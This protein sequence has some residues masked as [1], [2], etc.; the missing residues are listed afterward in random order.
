MNIR[1]EY[2]DINL[3]LNKEI[4]A[5]VEYL[6]KETNRSTENIFELAMTDF[7]QK[8]NHMFLQD[9]IYDYMLMD[10]ESGNE[11]KFEYD[12]FVVDLKYDD[13]FDYVINTHFME[14]GKQKQLSKVI[15]GDDELRHYL[16]QLTLMNLPIN[17]K[18]MQ[19]YVNR[20]TDYR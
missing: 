2:K 3:R 8:H 9:Y 7:L 11:S 5:D 20:R 4:I 19:D 18:F 6:S 16:G 1:K 14:D 15:I 17:D 13:K 10:I 12:G